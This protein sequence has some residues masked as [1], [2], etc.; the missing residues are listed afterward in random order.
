MKH[1]HYIYNSANS[2]LNEIQ[3]AH[4]HVITYIYEYLC[5]C[6]PVLY[7]FHASQRGYKVRFS[8]M[9]L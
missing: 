4:V 6:L 3:N 7:V 1:I 5:K 9:W 8:N 2:Q